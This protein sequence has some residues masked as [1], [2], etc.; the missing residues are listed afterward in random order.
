MTCQL[1]N[2]DAHLN[3]IELEKYE[4][5][6]FL[7]LKNVFS[8]DEVE[9]LRAAVTAQ[10]DGLSTTETGYDFES[11]AELVWS[12]ANDIGAGHADRFDLE[13]YKA[14]IDHD[15]LAR[16]IQDVPN[17]ASEKAGQFFYDAAGWRTHKGIRD[18]AL[19]SILPKLCAQL[20]ETDYLNFW[21]DTTFVKAPNTVQRTVFHQDYAYF[22]I[23][24]S[25]C[26]IVWIPLDPVS[27]KNGAM[28]YI[29]GSHLWN[30][31]YAPNL[32][33]TQT[34]MLDAEHPKLPDI[35]NNLGQYDI[36]TIPANPGDVI[37][38]NVMTVHGSGGNRSKDKNR[39]AM[40]F[41]YCG[42]DITYFDRPGAIPQPYISANLANGSPL[43]S[44]D[45]PLVW[46]RPY[47]NAKIAAMFEDMSTDT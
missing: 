16:P 30:K 11:L 18:A 37:I 31:T 14:M 6:G 45:Y 39:R 36:V 5:D 33:I 22:Q 29:R 38:H 20:M 12:G 21:E 7:H 2:I 8:S 23:R 24:G 41:R 10:L 26:C 28:Q 25:K 46:P 43:Y 40:S 13:L 34:P 35:E 19:D 4:Q 17:S 44:K 9:G 32:F 1:A 42:D 27:Q 47:P 15:G 3:E